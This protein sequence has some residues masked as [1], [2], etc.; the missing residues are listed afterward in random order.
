MSIDSISRT[1]SAQLGQEIVTKLSD[2]DMNWA[3]IIDAQMAAE[4]DF[5]YSTLESRQ[6][7]LATSKS[8]L[9][10]LQQSTNAFNNTIAGL[11][12]FDPFNNKSYTL[13]D[14]W[15]I[16]AAIDVDALA[17]NHSITIEQL[18]ASH[19]LS[20]NQTYGS[21]YDQL[22]EGQ[23]TI[24]LGTYEYDGTDTP[25]DFQPKAGQ[26]KLVIDL[27]STNNTL[28]AVAKQIN[29]SNVGVSAQVVDTGSGFKLSLTSQST[30][31]S[32]AIS[33]TGTNELA[34]AFNYNA[35]TQTMATNQKAENAILTLNGV[36]VEKQSN[37]V[38]D[39][40]DGVELDLFVAEPGKVI[41]LNVEMA[42]DFSVGVLEGFIE[43]YNLLIDNLEY[44][45]GNSEEI[46]DQE[47]FGALKSE[48]FTRELQAKM[49]DILS[50]SVGGFSLVDAGINFDSDYKHLTI[51]SVKAKE[52]LISS[53]DAFNNFFANYG[54]PTD[55]L[56]QFERF[57]PAATPGEYEIQ[58][59]QLAEKP[60]LTN[61]ITD[62]NLPITLNE[63]TGENQI[64]LKV[65]D[66]SEVTITLDAKTY[67]NSQELVDEL[68]TK[69]QYAFSGSDQNV[70]AKLDGNDLT[71]ELN[72]YGSA[73]SIEII[74][75]GSDIAAGLNLNASRA[76]GLDVRGYIGDGLAYGEGQT[77]TGLTG[78]GRDIVVNV[79]GGSVGAKD[80]PE[81]SRGTITYGQG[82]AAQ[83]SDFITDF[84]TRIDS[85]VSSYDEKL[86]D[87]EKE[88]EELDAR[89]ESRFTSL[90][91][92]YAKM[93]SDIAESESTLE[94]L[95][96]MFNSK[97]DD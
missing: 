8:S 21:R 74:S 50:T 59:T 56:I 63:G 39:L 25:I 55:P 83:M 40:I 58:V 52:T 71:L 13:S 12:E 2:G 1:N 32:N 95:D 64:T 41:S 6:E 61:T 69:L 94:Y 26:D 36:V 86:E 85:Q 65:N 87:L 81:A 30:G 73:K 27:D 37:N 35:Q 92:Q 28:D 46:E 11:T 44:Y 16:G 3:D 89:K 66:G 33:I 60:A 80:S 19:T 70:S 17:G 93:Q 7:K 79:L 78:D 88:V 15:N 72:E 57:D 53:P 5:K 4:F 24:E 10:L 54:Q 14:T 68:N 84:N 51:D 82:I 38:D 77:L 31:T 29:D 75:S 42:N 22:G 62:I 67:S 47:G 18:A 34:S 45:Q 20:S 76:E 43:E 23:L 90:S 49:Q 91:R 97:E 9:A 48:M 96:A